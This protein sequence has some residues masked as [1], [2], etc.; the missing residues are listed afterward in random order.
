MRGICAG[1]M[2]LVSLYSQ[3]Q[4]LRGV[5]ADE[6]DRTPLVGALVRLSDSSTTVTDEE[7]KYQFDF[8]KPGRYKLTVS[9]IAYQE[10]VVADILI[11]GNRTVQQDVGMNQ[12]PVSI[13]V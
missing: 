9:F 8:L 5:V 6:V 10:R 12:L 1:V 3:G 13:L 7:G 11:K 4:V 2:L